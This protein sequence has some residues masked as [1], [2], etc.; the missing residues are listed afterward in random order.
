VATGSGSSNAQAISNYGSGYILRSSSSHAQA[1]SLIGDATAVTGGSSLGI[2]FSGTIESTGTGGVSL[3]GAAGTASVEAGITTGTANILAKSGAITLVGMNDSSNTGLNLGTVNLGFKSGTNVTTSSSN[4]VL[5]ADVYGF[6]T[7]ALNTTGTVEIYS[8]DTSASFGTAPTLPAT[9]TMGTGVTGLTI[10]KTTNTSTVTLNNSANIN[11]PITVDGG[12]I[13]L[14]SSLQSSAAGAGITIRAKTN[15]MNTAVATLTTA[16]GNI[17]L[18]SNVD[19]ASDSD[20]TTNGYIRMDFGLNAT[21]NG[22]HITLGGGNLLGT[23]YA[24]GSS[25]EDQTHGLR[26][27][28]TVNLNS[29]GGTIALRGKSYA[30]AVA[31]GYGGSGVGFYFLT[32]SGVIDSGTGTVYIDGYSQTSGSAYGSGVYFF[33]QQAFTIKSAN[34]TTDAIKI[35]AKATGTSG[36]SWGIEQEDNVL[37]ILAT[38]TGGGITLTTSQKLSHE[39]VFR[40][41]LNVLAKSGPITWTTKADADGAANGYWFNGYAYWGSKSGSLVPASSSNISIAVDNFHW[42]GAAPYFATTGT[43]EIKPASDSFAAAN[44][45]TSWFNYNQNLQTMGG[46]TFGKP[47]NNTPMYVDAAISANGPINLYGGDMAVQKA[48]TATGVGAGIWAQARGNLTMSGDLTHSTN[49]GDITLWSDADGS[50][51]GYIYFHDRIL[52]DSRSSA[53]RTSSLISTA[54]GGGSITLGGGSASTTLA[55][56]TVVPTGFAIDAS[57]S[58]P[59]GVSLGYFNAGHDSGNK[60]YSGG[61]DITVRGKNTSVWL[62]DSSGIAALDGLTMDAGT[63]GNITL[64]G[65]GGNAGASYSSGLYLNYW[66]NNATAGSL[67]KTKDGNISFTGTGT[68]ATNKRGILLIGGTSKSVTLAATGTGSVTLNGSGATQ[69]NLF[70]NSNILAASGDININGL[71]AGPLAHRHGG[72]HHGLQVW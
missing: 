43:L 16:G 45:F 36:D 28:K 1:I 2:N 13:N 31:A 51:Q 67:F 57:N 62:S 39:G 69:D 64:E 46:F 60:F 20:S 10:G 12:Q 32:S 11:G 29:A 44:A 48:L 66:G 71:S 72:D 33:T 9:F 22:G 24:M 18:A 68:L 53:N 56:G 38:E 5:K 52:V 59:G 23:S 25:W 14:N 34:T 65:Q 41:E 54:S 70:Y 3:I 7:T 42:T 27:D 55:S 8:L 21:S 6:G 49:A 50:G 30:R 17:L 37:S 26:I 47:G 61:G 63:T 58:L 19:D 15:I 40:S 35:I 4:I